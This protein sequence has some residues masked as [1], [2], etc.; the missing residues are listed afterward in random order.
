MYGLHES[1]LAFNNLLNAKLVEIG[2]TRSSADSCLYI[3]HY[4]TE[5]IYLTV[6]VDDMFLASP[7]KEARSWFENQ[8]KKKFDLVSQHDTVSYLGMSISK[9]NRLITV[10]QKGYIDSMATKFRVNMDIVPSSP[11]GTNFLD[12]NSTSS[13]MDTSKY[14]S[15]VMSLM[16][17]ARFTRADILMPVT[18]LATKSANPTQD[19][20]NKLMRILSYV[21]G[22]ASMSLNFTP[23]QDLRVQIWADASHML[24]KDGKGHGGII[25]TLGSAPIFTKSFKI[26][27]ITRS[28]TESEM[29]A[30]EESV[31]Y[32]L[33]LKAILTDL[34]I[35]PF[36]PAIIYQD[37]KSTIII[38]T[39][40]GS[41]SRSKH[42]TNRQQFLNQHVSNNDVTLKYCP[43]K[44]MP[45]DMLTKPLSHPDLD[46]LRKIINIL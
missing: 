12:T 1:P 21:V 17:L 41:F 3:H 39:Q 9:T 28:S 8:M 14:L 5:V 10:N 46:R 45:A 38:A 25:G 27:L 15:L 2:F 4:R 22:T 13:P 40:G 37:N 42:I 34:R 23:V 31:T 24:H 36:H 19:D 18:Y 7:N 44:E 32:A 29:V 26:K 35:R 16:Y 20:Y 6:H 30:L 43:T 11:T 33:W